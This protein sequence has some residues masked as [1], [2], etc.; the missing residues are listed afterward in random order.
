[1]GRVNVP[2]TGFESGEDAVIGGLARRDGIDAEPELRDDDAVVEGNCCLVHGKGC[3]LID[4]RSV[5]IPR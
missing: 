1:M 5:C 2:V 4:F 3:V